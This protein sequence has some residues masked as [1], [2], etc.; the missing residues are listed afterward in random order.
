MIKNAL[1]KC[2]LIYPMPQ[3]VLYLILFLITILILL[4]LNQSEHPSRKQSLYIK[5]T[6]DPVSVQTFVNADAEAN[7]FNLINLSPVDD[8]NHNYNIISDKKHM[9][10]IFHLRKLSITNTNIKI[11]NGLGLLPEL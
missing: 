3:L 1:C 9:K 11:Q 6:S 2:N 4:H 7:I 5:K 10:T 8:P